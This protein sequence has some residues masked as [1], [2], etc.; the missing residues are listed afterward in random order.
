MSDV[1][2]NITVEQMEY[3]VELFNPCMDDYLFVYDLNHDYYRISQNAV[4]RFKLP[5]GSFYHAGEML[6]QVVV[7]QDMPLLQADLD[8]IRAGEITFHNLHYRWLN[9]EDE[10]VWINC[11]GRVILDEDGKPYL[12]VGCINEIGKKQKADNVSGLLGETS[13]RAYVDQFGPKKPDGFL[14]RIGIDGLKD[15]NGSLGAKYGDFILKK[16]ADCIAENILPHQKLYRI[17]ADEFM[18]VDF[19]GATANDAV[20]LYKDI[21]RSVD[22]FIEENGYRSVYTISAG[23]VDLAVCKDS[24][25]Y[26]MKIS[27]FAINEAKR[28]GRN[29]CYIYNTEDYEQFQKKKTLTR[30]LRHAVDHNFEGFEV[31][32]QPLVNA[33]TYQ[34]IGAEALMR[35]TMPDGTKVSPVVFIPILEETGLIIPTGRWILNQALR[36]CKQWQKYIPDFRMNVNLSYVQVMKSHVV[37]DIMTAIQMYGLKNSC[38]GIELT[39]S[40]YLDS[41]AHFESMWKKLKEE[42]VLLVLDDFGTGYSNLHCLTELDPNYIKIDRTFAMKALTHPYEYNLLVQIIEMAHHLKLDICV[43][44]IE[45]AEELERVR[46]M[47]VDYI[48]GYLFGKPCD[49]DAFM[50]KFI[51]PEPE[52]SGIL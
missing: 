3:I 15:I 34:L 19:S 47:G 41:G 11:R 26:L 39:E 46:N 45:T 13:L 18:V 9:R 10:P 31:Y 52:L 30:Q 43:E 42:G 38:V 16:T 44:G 25:E 23:V 5:G 6:G 21:R 27:E 14:L 1:V 8:R 35:F 33:G 12:L 48:Q 24:Y 20:A 37:T 50:E 29:R 36:T 4:E 17:I 40:G 7:E 32:Y 49:A 22:H 2:H 51:Q 28:L